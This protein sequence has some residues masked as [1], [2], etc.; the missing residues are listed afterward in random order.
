VSEEVSV[1]NQSTR[2]ERIEYVGTSSSNSGT[3]NSVEG[4][5]LEDIRVVNEFP[6]VF[7]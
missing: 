3:A 7:P 6:D 5:T 2:R 4:K 1:V